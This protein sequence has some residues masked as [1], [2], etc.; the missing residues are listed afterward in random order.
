MLCS[1]VTTQLKL[2]EELKVSKH[3]RIS[4]I[5]SEHGLLRDKECSTVLSQCRNQVRILLTQLLLILEVRNSQFLQMFSIKSEVNGLLLFQILIAHQ[6]KH[7]VMSR[8]VAKMLLQNFNQ[9][10]SR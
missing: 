8:I 4:R 3:S 7:S 9:L 6:I 5:G 10:G 2:L 1:V